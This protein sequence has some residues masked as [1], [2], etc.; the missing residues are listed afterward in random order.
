LQ[1]KKWRNGSEMNAFEPVSLSH[2]YLLTRMSA[3]YQSSPKTSSFQV[4]FI[5]IYDY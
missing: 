4:K 1:K 3:H 2:T 5:F